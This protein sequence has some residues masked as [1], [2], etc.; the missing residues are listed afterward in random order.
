MKKLF[1]FLLITTFSISAF[2]NVGV[3][4]ETNKN[5]TVEGEQLLHPNKYRLYQ[6]NDDYIKSFLYKLPQSPDGAQHISLPAPD[7]TFMQFRIWETPVMPEQLAAKFPEIKNFTAVSVDNP[8]VTAK[9]NYNSYGFSAMVF[10]GNKTYLVDPYTN[11]NTGYYLC[12]YK[13]DHPR[14]H[15]RTYGCMKQQPNE[16]IGGEKIIIGGNDEPPSFD[17]KVHGT[18]RKTFRLALTCTGEYA[19][20]VDGTNPDKAKVVTAMTNT[21]NR[22]NG[23]FEK[24]F[25]ATMV[26]VADNDQIVYLDPANDP[27]TTTANNQVDPLQAPNQTNT[28]AIIGDANYDIGHIFCSGNSGIADTNGLCDPGYKARA[29]TGNSSPFGDPF[30]ID[31]VAH[32]MGH[33]FGAP[34]TFNTGANSCGNF[35]KPHA[36][37]E[38]GGGTTIMGYAGLCGQDNIQ[39]SSDDYFHGQSLDQV[40]DYLSTPAILACGSTTP[41]NNTPPVV[42]DIN[43]TYNIPF[44]TPFELEAPQ[45]VDTDHDILTYCWEEFDLG[46]AGATFQ[47]TLY[48]PIFRSFKPTASRWRVFPIMD[49]IRNNV[50]DYLGEKLPTVTRVVSF[51]LTVR[52]VYNGFGTFNLSDNKVNLNVTDQAGPFVVTGPNAAS[53]YWQIGQTYTVTW[54]VANTNTAPVN[55]TNVDIYLSLDDGRTYPI[56]LAANTPNDG[57]EQIT[58]PNSG[59]SSMAR[60]KVKGNNN[61]FFDIS[62]EGFPVSMWPAGVANVSFEKDVNVYPVPA[63]E[64][65]NITINNNKKYSL[66]LTNAVGQ[67]V[68][69]GN[70]TG[71]TSINTTTYS[72]G[73]YHLSIVEK[74]SG[75]RLVKRVVIQ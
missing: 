26:L 61:V 8:A 51:K 31:Y 74:L 1:T 52:D 40:T 64:Q 33:Q 30:D 6:L 70:A 68:W 12:Y 32:E 58:V 45:A 2:A 63:D 37:F 23:I 13:N 42:P 41:S 72:A 53:D 14:N 62:N 71:S 24:D 49:S 28:D 7:G 57:S 38:P 47:N 73:V 25:G 21:L 60:V 36:A 44:K 9:I 48:G 59:M 75:E 56:V 15:N 39:F 4:K 50:T 66:Q 3:W 67:L 18:T 17:A 29:A 34:H 19:V 22:V 16:D 35:V 43:V 54:D 27:F 69:S 55:C 11:V 10:D 65:L 46:D 5:I 20:A